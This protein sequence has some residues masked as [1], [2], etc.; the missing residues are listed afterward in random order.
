MVIK[1]DRWYPY[2]V[3]I[4]LIMGGWLHAGTKRTDHIHTII[5]SAQ[6]ADYVIPD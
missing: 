5:A 2:D 3:Y 4:P 1:I 6:E